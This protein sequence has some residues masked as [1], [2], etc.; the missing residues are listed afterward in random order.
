MLLRY[1]KRLIVALGR[2]DV[3]HGG[4]RGFA[5]G[6]LVPPGQHDQR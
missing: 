3:A 1:L 6:S 4:G 2:S 5:F